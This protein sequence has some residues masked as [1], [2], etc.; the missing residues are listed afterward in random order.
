[1]ARGLSIVLLCACCVAAV[2]S[3]GQDPAAAIG[4]Q[5]AA[6]S[7]VEWEVKDIDHPALG[8]IRFASRKAAAATAV[9]SQKIVTQL[10]VSCQKRTGNIAMELSN[11]PESNP[12]G[13]LAPREIP[14][15][16]CY[17]PA[18]GGGGRLVEAEI[19]AKWE[20]NN[21]GDALARGLAPRELRR[22]VSIDV[23]QDLVLPPGWERG[24]QQVLT[25]ILPYG[26]ALEAVF[27][28]CGEAKAP[29][30]AKP[31][32]GAG[33]WKPARSTMKGRT[34]LRAAASVDSPLAGQLNPGTRLLVQEASADWW[35]VKPRSGTAFAGFVRKDRVVLE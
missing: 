32:P 11:A 31:S 25:E 1:V 5:R 23:L 10:Y 21:L 24:S 16:T 15:L 8:P 20:V 14:R 27:A 9:G 29:L 33:Q 12:A 18:P 35:K 13:G 22:C 17:S 3:R 4:R 19:H 2:P 6:A 26:P 7:T 30:A 28:A 34:N